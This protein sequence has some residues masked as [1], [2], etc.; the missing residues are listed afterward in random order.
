MREK[1]REATVGDVLLR[2][3]K[4]NK[5]YKGAVILD[6]AVRNVSRGS[7]RDRSR[8]SDDQSGDATRHSSA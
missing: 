7:R 3:F 2:L 4:K 5:A 6:K 8:G 1:I